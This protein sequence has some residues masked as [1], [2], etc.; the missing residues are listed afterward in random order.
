MEQ[1]QVAV[2]GA[3]VIGLSI[4][5]ELAHAGHAV[6]VI[7][8]DHDPRDCSP[9]AGAVWFPYGVSLDADVIEL[10]ERTRLRFE[11]LADASRGIARRSG[12]F[13]VRL[14]E[15]DMAWTDALPGKRELTQEEVPDGALGGFRVTVPVI[16]MSKYLVWLRAIVEQ[17]GVRF[18]RRLINDLASVEADVKI[19]A[20]GLRSPELVP[21]AEPIIP[22]RGQIVRLENPGLTDWYVDDDAPGGLTYVI[23]RFDDIVCGGTDDAGNADA[24]H[25]PDIETGILERVTA[26]M[27][28]LQGLPIVSRGVG[29]RPGRSEP[30]IEWITDAASPTIA[31]YGHGGAGVSMSWGCAERVA[32]MVRER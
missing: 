11:E 17:L 13:I 21:D 12:R 26:A 2:I 29:L 25:D 1:K 16:D 20:A 4:A 10:S 6:T 28:E 19:V 9:L 3:G 31:C 18:E 14:P 5:H 7:A 8:D 24:E 32:D 23:P 15:T 22:R 27:P 30:R